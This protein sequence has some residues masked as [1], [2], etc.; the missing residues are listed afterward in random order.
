MVRIVGGF[1]ALAWQRA[2]QV[3]L[4]HEPG[5]SGRPGPGARAAAAAGPPQ[6]RPAGR[7]S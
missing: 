5:G 2:G 6:D 3:G 7:T 4:G 1:E